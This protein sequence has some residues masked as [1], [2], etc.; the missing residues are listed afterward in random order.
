MAEQHGAERKLQDLPPLFQESGLLEQ[1]NLPPKLIRFL[2]RNQRAIWAVLVA[3]IV[4]A[5]AIAGYNAYTDHRRAKG[6]EALDR[7]MQAGEGRR[8]LLQQVRDEYSS[9]PSALW[10][11]VALA[12]MDEQD[13]KAGE[14]IQRY[15]AVRAKLGPNSQLMPLVLGK[16]AVLEEQSKNWDASL[17][18][19]QELAKLDGFAADAQLN[20]GRLYEAQG[21]KDEALGMYKKFL[22]FTAVTT[23]QNGEDP[24]RQMIQSHIELL[25]A[26]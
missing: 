4:L 1:F 24:R 18:Y 16:L 21:K 14:A 5:L 13:N 3:A 19:Y 2:R 22:E 11:E 17:A 7:A 15:Q 23:E 9:T 12:R 26:K 8:D 25:Q 6:A 20:M 10:A